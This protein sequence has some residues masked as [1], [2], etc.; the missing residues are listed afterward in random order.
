MSNSRRPSTSQVLLGLFVAG[1]L[2]FLFV[3]NG[4]E[5]AEQTRQHLPERMRQAANR[6][7]PGWADERGQLN[8]LQETLDKTTKAY[9]QATEQLQNWSLFA[10]SV[11][12]ECT[13]P[14]LLLRWDDDLEP[15][16]KVKNP[17]ALL[18]AGNSLH[19]LALSNLAGS[20]PDWLK[21]MERRWLSQHLSVLAASHSLEA[22]TVCI[23]L[24]AP[25]PQ[26]IHE[27]PALILSDN[28]PKDM[29]AFLRIGNYRLRKFEESFLLNLSVKDGESEA[30]ARERWDGQIRDHLHAWGQI[31]QGY[32]RWRLKQVMNRT[33]QDDL[34][35]EV[36]LLQRRYEIA[37]PEDAPPFIR[38]PF[39][40]PL[41]RWQPRLKWDDNHSPLEM[42]DPVT[43]TFR[44]RRK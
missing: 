6:L 8:H 21:T 22:A 36:I 28:E 26:R 17:L 14:A 15:G 38:G 11:A 9:S 34:P 33:Q 18:A 25:S 39:V 20:E 3:R 5:L 10:P 29:T 2:L 42:Y 30:Q 44:A 24:F 27:K 32:M 40:M 35:H 13:F 1:Q 19:A 23:V 12:R 16:V 31:I 41:A 43:D 4:V 37:R 7:A